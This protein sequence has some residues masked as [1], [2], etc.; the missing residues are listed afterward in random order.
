MQTDIIYASHYDTVASIKDMIKNHQ[1][2]RICLVL[3]TRLLLFN[4]SQLNILRRYCA[5][6]GLELALV[7][8]EFQTLQFAKQLNIQQYPSIRRARK[9]TWY[10]YDNQ[11]QELLD[12]PPPYTKKDLDAL[13]LKAQQASTSPKLSRSARI[14][15]IT[16][17]VIALLFL[18]GYLI[19]SATI[20]LTP[21]KKLQDMEI[22][23]FDADG[24]NLLKNI[25]P[26][27]T[28]TLTLS[29]QSQLPTTGEISV[30]HT[31]ATGT[32]QFTNISNAAVEI[33]AGTTLYAV[34]D[35]QQILV[36]TTSAVT[37]PAE[38]GSTLTTEIIASNPGQLGN[39]P[40]NTITNIVG[41]LSFYVTANNP[42]AMTGGTDQTTQAPSKDDY[43]QL[44]TQLTQTIR[45]L[46]QDKFSQNSPEGIQ[47]IN[48]TLTN[49][50]EQFSPTS[51]QSAADIL[52]LE[53]E[54]DVQIEYLTEQDLI[55]AF[56]IALDAQLLP[57]QTPLENS[58]TYEKLTQEGQTYYQG[59]R[60]TIQEIN[61]QAIIQS[62]TGKT[63][64]QA[65]NMLT[66]Q[67]G[68]T[69][70]PQILFKPN[71]L[72]SIPFYRLP[73]SEL[74]IYFEMR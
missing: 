16:S 15:L 31:T 44:R 38:V 60:L 37:L 46:A 43:T 72:N 4:A 7:T 23:L 22:P 55:N 10:L 28:T 6:L 51:A 24:N 54:T 59:H 27:H 50:Q 13:K 73:L 57:G 3:P 61:T 39:L 70:S 29:S 52:S 63:K 58:F 26:I 67:L 33:P 1:S 5:D 74:R 66:N 65:I 14:I 48:L 40:A 69:A 68:E 53:I 17:V 12:S 56:T 62:L 9:S 25:L 49:T 35:E 21:E 11:D 34:I 20:F 47:I 42:I 36:E 19:P 32:I 18:A 2:A 30:P 71:F 64:T 41:N 45:Q 8:R